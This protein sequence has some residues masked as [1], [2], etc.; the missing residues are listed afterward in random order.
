MQDNFSVT[1]CC[2]SARIKSYSTVLPAGIDD[3]LADYTL[4]PQSIRDFISCLDE[5]E[6]QCFSD[7]TKVDLVKLKLPLFVKE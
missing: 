4:Q 3:F 2:D 7:E 1:L 6:S 5:P